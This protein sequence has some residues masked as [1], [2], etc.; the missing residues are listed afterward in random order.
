MKT[1]WKRFTTW[2]GRTWARFK[3]WFIGLLVSIGMIS[4]AV[5]APVAV[6]YVPATQYTDGSPMPIDEI[7]ETRL[8]CNGALVTTESGA[9]GSFDD[10]SGLLPVGVSQCYGTHVATN[11]I[12][13]GQSNTVSVTVISSAAPNPP[14]LTP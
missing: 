3:K 5:V 10:V 7:A 1:Y 11:G 14:E 12:E 6:N 4:V 9:D 8:Y 13:S 2:S